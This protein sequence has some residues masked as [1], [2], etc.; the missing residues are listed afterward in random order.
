MGFITAPFA[1]PI[2]ECVGPRRLLVIITFPVAGLWLVQAYSPCLWLL[3]LARALMAIS[4]T[5]VHTVMNPLTAELFP[6]HIRGMAAALPEAFGCAGLL[7]SYLLASLLPWDT[8]T[9]VSAAPFLFLSFMMLLVPES[10]YW[11][12][13]K[14]KI[15]AAERS[16]RLLLG[17]DGNVAEELAAIRSTTTLAQS[18]IKDQLRELRKK[19][20][21][22]PV[23]L[24]LS[25][26]ILRE[27]GGKGPVFYYTVYMFRKA[28]VQMNVF[29]C[30]VF[31]G[32]CR[33][34]S[35]CVSA[36]TLDVLGRRPLL[37]ATALICAVSEGIAG[38]FLILEI[39]GTEWVPLASVIVFVIGY[40]IG[41]G[42]IPWTYLGELL[43][44]PV[45]S[46][47]ASII[48][49][50]YSITLFIISLVF[51]K[52]VSYLGL[53]LTLLLFGGA[54]LAIVPLVLL[55]IPETK[56]RT[57]QDLEKAFTPKKK[58]V[59]A[60]DNP[61]LEMDLPYSAEGKGNTT[62][63]FDTTTMKRKSES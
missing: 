15:D 45:R 35:T 13:R 47:G 5:M 57:L 58:T 8:T 56:G 22:I 26:F 48:T 50:V 3:Y 14:N 38:A 60:E 18:E 21:A 63:S 16:L 53:G 55:F 17:H 12:V 32:I 29:Y 27:L 11:L 37:A 31:I 23:L 33:L 41:L 1:G 52:E 10:P 7:L 59:Q 20:N 39:E 28:G 51:L 9:A 30:T 43:P 42:P 40:G 25:I 2:A 49:L 54:N 34:A 6:A 4:G 46:L 19:Q 61:A 24:T 44:T 36:C 62:S